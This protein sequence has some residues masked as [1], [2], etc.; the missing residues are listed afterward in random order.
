MIVSDID[1]MIE[2]FCSLIQITLFKSPHT[3]D[4]TDCEK[5]KITGKIS[6]R[7]IR[8]VWFKFNL[9]DDHRN[10]VLSLRTHYHI[11]CSASE[12]K[13]NDHIYFIPYL[14]HTQPKGDELYPWNSAKS[15]CIYLEFD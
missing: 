3:D 11:L 13:G 4:W 10:D 9:D 7:Y 14:L 2:V 8:H 6:E 5:I 1:W 15:K 12:L